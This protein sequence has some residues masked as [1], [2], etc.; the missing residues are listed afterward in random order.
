[1]AAALNYRSAGTAEYLVDADTGRYYFLE[2]NT[3]L[4]VEHGITEAV[5]GID[6]VEWMVRVAGGETVDLSVAESGY[7]L[8]VRICAEDPGKDFLPSSGLLT[9]VVFPEDVRCDRWI[10]AGTVVPAGEWLA[11]RI[12]SGEL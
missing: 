6:L 2:I 8:E 7:A 3:R 12:A 10:T 11:I 4:Q 1:M 9:E 5:T